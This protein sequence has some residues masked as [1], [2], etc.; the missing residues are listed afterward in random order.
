MT[1]H[2]TQYLNNIVLSKLAESKSLIIDRD[3]SLIGST[4]LAGTV[5]SVFQ[6]MRLT[7]LKTMEFLA[8]ARKML[9]GPQDFA[10]VQEVVKRAGLV[11]QNAASNMSHREL[12]MMSKML[13]DEILL[14][15][16]Y[17]DSDYK[18]LLNAFAARHRVTLAPY[19]EHL[20]PII[21]S[22]H[23]VEEEQQSAGSEMGQQDAQA[24]SQEMS[25]VAEEPIILEAEVLPKRLPAS[26]PVAGTITAA[27]AGIMGSTLAKVG[28][29]ALGAL[30]TGVSAYYTYQYMYGVPGVQP[31][32]PTPSIPVIPTVEPKIIPPKIPVPSPKVPFVEPIK[33]AL[34]SD[35]LPSIVEPEKVVPVDAVNVYEPKIVPAPYKIAFV[36]EVTPKMDSYVVLKTHT[37]KAQNPLEITQL[38]KIVHANQ[39]NPSNQVAVINQQQ[40]AVP[41]PLK[42]FSIPQRKKITNNSDRLDPLHDLGNLFVQNTSRTQTDRVGVFVFTLLGLGAAAAFYTLTRN[43]ATKPQSV[44]LRSVNVVSTTTTNASSTINNTHH[45]DPS[46][47]PGAGVGLG[48]VEPN[49]NRRTTNELAPSF[50]THIPNYLAQIERAI[51]FAKG[52]MAQHQMSNPQ[53]DMVEQLVKLHGAI[54]GQRNFTPENFSQTAGVLFHAYRLLSVYFDLMQTEPVTKIKK[55]QIEAKFTEIARTSETFKG[56]LQK[57]EE[58]LPAHA[59]LRL[60]S[61]GIDQSVANYKVMHN[62]KSSDKVGADLDCYKELH[63]SLRGKMRSLKSANI[64]AQL[65]DMPTSLLSGLLDI[66]EK[67]R[68]SRTDHFTRSN[69]HNQQVYLSPH[70]HRNPYDLLEGPSLRSRTTLLLQQGNN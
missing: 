64:Q 36:K 62:R 23:K 42:L 47:S 46:N 63:E 2:N 10:L 56:R 34:E 69:H 20:N 68:V 6:N 1:V 48:G 13:A 57:G 52:F 58:A 54:D 51:S 19:E 33:V 45:R 43:R 44:T 3:R 24:Q 17:A 8:Q 4:S 5:K 37:L 49:N 66:L 28:V 31:T 7:E 29:V 59:L 40:F 9:R 26:H 32:V 70:A 67:Q 41:T 39:P 16:H 65:L 38:L 50:E 18:N 53:P 14:D 60:L 30:A 35:P 11:A 61:D 22:A 55:H 21:Q 12:R 25:V 15:K 27:Y